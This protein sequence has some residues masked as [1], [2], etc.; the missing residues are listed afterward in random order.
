MNRI[1]AILAVFALLGSSQCSLAADASLDEARN[2]LQADM[3]AIHAAGEPTTVDDLKQPAVP[4]TANGV[5]EIRSAYDS[6][7]TSTAAYNRFTRIDPLDPLNPDTLQT[8]REVTAENAT[9]LDLVGAALAKG[10]FDWQFKLASPLITVPLP[11]L[12]KLRG[13][14]IV[15]RASAV[16]AHHEDNDDLALQRI[17]QLLGL[18]R[19]ADQSQILISHLV[20]LG[21]GRHATDAA[22]QIA[23][24][25]KAPTTS[26]A[27]KR[28]LELAAALLDDKSIQQKLRLALMTERVNVFDLAF[29]IAEDRISAADLDQIINPS[30]APRPQPNLDPSIVKRIALEDAHQLLPYYHDLIAAASA[31]DWPMLRSKLPNP[32]VAAPD[33]YF[34][35]A[36]M[37]SADKIFEAQYRHIAGRRL[38]AIALGTR[39][40]ALDNGGK[41]PRKIGDLAPKYLSS[42]PTD[43]FTAGK[44]MNYDPDQGILYSVGPDGKDDGGKESGAPRPQPDIVVRL[45]P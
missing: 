19:T 37:L 24:T 43:P 15:V 32:P 35:S 41:L 33:R 44:P 4:D 1:T 7:D 42:I 16:A 36:A 20:A 23:P 11:D 9:A 13:V 29:A 3:A 6:I 27:R 25:L 45:R 26:P 18:S 8:L 14:A 5:L 31:P 17:G 2:V 38:A 40:F 21:I 12:A 10:E 39:C 22:D 30:Q 34:R 28:A